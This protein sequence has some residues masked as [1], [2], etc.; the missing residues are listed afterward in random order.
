MNRHLTEVDRYMAAAR[1]A[2]AAQRA[3]L[4]GMDPDRPEAANS[5][6]L[7][8]M[9]EEEGAFHRGRR[10]RRGGVGV[11]WARCCAPFDL[12]AGGPVAGQCA[13]GSAK[14]FR[15]IARLTARM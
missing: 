11:L 6:E 8:A 2:I 5:R 15:P 10:G 12:A 9:S 7:L 13:K 14:R 3:M 4:E 1:A